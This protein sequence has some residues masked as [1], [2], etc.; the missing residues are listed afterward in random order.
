MGRAQHCTILRLLPTSRHFAVRGALSG[1][2]KFLLKHPKGVFEKL[3]QLFFQQQKLYECL[4]KDE[5]K[6]WI[7]LIFSAPHRKIPLENL[8]DVTERVTIFKKPQSK[9]CANS[10]FFVK[11]Q[12]QNSNFI[13]A[14]YFKAITSFFQNQSDRLSLSA[15]TNHSAE[16]QKVNKY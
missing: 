1:V 3:H 16:C 6:K 13:V 10:S 4:A 2:H 12:I 11:N 7:F 14:K 8:I 9:Y 15:G 5:L